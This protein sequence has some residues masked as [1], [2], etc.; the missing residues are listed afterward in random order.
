MMA[1]LGDEPSLDIESV[2]LFRGKGIPA[3]MIEHPQFE[4]Y[5]KRELNPDDASDRKLVE[6][7]FCT[8]VG[9]QI[10]GRT[11]QDCKMHK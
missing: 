1:I 2:W 10:N 9:L 3:Q 8:K 7:F 5:Q 6:E 4:Y 11:V